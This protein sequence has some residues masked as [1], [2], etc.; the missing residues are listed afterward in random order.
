[1]FT[2]AGPPA[3]LDIMLGRALALCVHPYAAWRVLSTT[4][5]S[6]MLA[7]YAAFGYVMGMLVFLAFPVA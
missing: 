3:G 7:A 6:L 1:M 5:R 2:A 4:G